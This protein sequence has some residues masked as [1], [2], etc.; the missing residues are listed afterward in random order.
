MI[1]LQN[2]MLEFYSEG[3]HGLV[4]S[5]VQSGALQLEIRMLLRQLS[6][7]TYAIKNQLKTLKAGSLRVVIIDPF[8]A[9]K[10]LIMP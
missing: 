5:P 10:P 7:I 4:V 9:W 1:F 2:E 8:R 6:L 3:H